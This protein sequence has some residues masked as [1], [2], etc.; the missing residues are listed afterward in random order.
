MTSAASMSG[1]G[2]VRVLPRN[3][4]RTSSGPTSVRTTGTKRLA[5]RTSATPAGIQ[6]GAGAAP[7][8]RAFAAW[9]ATNAARAATAP[10]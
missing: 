1:Y 6:K 7:A 5:M 9:I 2:I 8:A 10:P 4:T 3:A